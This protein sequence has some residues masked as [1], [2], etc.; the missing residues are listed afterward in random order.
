MASRK[1]STTEQAIERMKAA[2]DRARVRVNSDNDFDISFAPL[3]WWRE[4]WHDR[5]IQRQFIENFIYV[6][7]AFDENKL[8]LL[9]LNE[10]QQHLHYNVTGKDIV[11]KSRR[12]GLSTYFKARYFAKC[13]VHS[14]RNF[15]EVP[16][17]PDTEAQFRKAF[18]RID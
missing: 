3:S 5:E 10:I 8:T 12:Q 9:K 14:G 17:D 4:R 7:D 15:R 16:H 18:F 1:K 11:I 2:N 6:R 13:V